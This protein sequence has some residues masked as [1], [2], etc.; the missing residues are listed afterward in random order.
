MNKK[1][2]EPELIIPQL[3]IVFVTNILKKDILTLGWPT[4]AILSQPALSLYKSKEF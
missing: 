3:T 1:E 2:F 4:L